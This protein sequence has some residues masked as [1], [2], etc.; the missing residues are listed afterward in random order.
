MALLRS[1]GSYQGLIKAGL[2]DDDIGVPAFETV[3]ADAYAA[4][5]DDVADVVLLAR[6]PRHPRR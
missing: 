1:Q 6:P 5:G 2:T 4:A 3:V